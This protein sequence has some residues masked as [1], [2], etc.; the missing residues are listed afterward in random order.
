MGNKGRRAPSGK[1][2]GA[3][4]KSVVTYA[5]TSAQFIRTHKQEFLAGGLVII[6]VV[7]LFGVVSYFQ[8]PG[9]NAAQSGETT[10]DYSAFIAQV[11]AGNVLAATIRGSDVHGLLISPLAQSN[12][13]ATATPTITATQRATDLSTYSRYL[14]TN[15]GWANSQQTPAIAPSRLVYT[16]EPDAGDPTLMPL[17]VN[18]HVIVTTQPPAQPS[19]LLTLLWRIL[20][21]VFFIL[22]ALFLLAPRN[23]RRAAGGSDEHFQQMGKSKARRF[24]QGLEMKEK[25]KSKNE[26]SFNMLKPASPTPGG[27]NKADAAAQSKRLPPP[28][29]FQDVAGIDEVREE[30]EEIV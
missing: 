3:R 11:K 2:R 8:P 25:K 17:L 22:A 18:S 14:G 1:G 9:T 10:I 20:P 5:R 7:L 12:G 6:L 23:P 21:F 16:R 30:L 29:T 13:S 28:V 19:L 24:E 4:H 15:S 26:P 27:T